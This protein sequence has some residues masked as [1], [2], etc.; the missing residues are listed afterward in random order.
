MSASWHYTRPEAYLEEK[1]SGKIK[2]SKAHNSCKLFWR[3]VPV[4]KSLPRLTNVLIIWESNESTFLIRWASSMMMYSQ[5]NFRSVDF[6]RIH[7]S[8]DVMRMSNFWA[9]ITSVTMLAFQ[10][11]HCA[12]SARLD[13]LGPPWF[14]GVLWSWILEPTFRPL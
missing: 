2:F 4:I 13:L 12:G 1:T 11:R 7:I 8:Y 9:R 5:L 14:P 3:G 10:V 6:S